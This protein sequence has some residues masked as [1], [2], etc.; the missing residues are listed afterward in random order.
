MTGAEDWYCQFSDP[1]PENG[2]CVSAGI[3]AMP[4][5]SLIL[6]GEQTGDLCIRA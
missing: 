5:N 3:I 4:G 6:L 1:L 2:L